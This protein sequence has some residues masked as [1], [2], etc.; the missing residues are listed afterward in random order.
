MKE[1]RLDFLVN[2]PLNKELS[3]LLIPDFNFNSIA[4]K[5][6]EL[7]LS[8]DKL[9]Q[10]FSKNY[11]LP[12][13]FAI[14]GFLELFMNFKKIYYIDS[15]HYEIR[16]SLE[17]ISNVIEIERID[18]KNLYCDLMKID[19]ELLAKD[20]TLIILPLINEDIFSI[21][22]IPNIKNATLALDIS[23]ASRLGMDIGMSDIA[24]IN[25]ATF[26]L[27]SGFGLILSDKIYTSTLYK[28]GVSEAFCRALDEQIITDSTNMD[29]FAKLKELLENDID[30]FAQDFAPNTL[31][32]RFRHINTRNLI[33]H[34]YLD[35]IFL[36]GSQDC[37]LGFIKPSHTLTSLGFGQLAAR[38]LCAISFDKID[39]ISLIA[40]K[41][42]E[43]YK[44]IRLMEF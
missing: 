20:S 5:E 32:L 28:K 26:G 14:G 43:S 29:L 8:R 27:P 9:K 1:I 34:L 13:N 15:L 4:I 19:D 44:M 7:E 12:F 38:E 11:A 36:S 10:R 6:Q 31:P 35:N 21:N 22:K 41:M 30:L 3:S 17:I 37:Y 23:Y 42:A 40:S 39:D 24:L 2:P 25:G 18:M 16:R 33:Q